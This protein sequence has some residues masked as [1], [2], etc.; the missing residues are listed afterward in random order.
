MSTSFNGFTNTPTATTKR[1]FSDDDGDL[2]H[3]LY[4]WIPPKQKPDDLTEEEFNSYLQTDEGIQ[5]LENFR[6]SRGAPIGSYE[7][8]TKEPYEK[9]KKSERKKYQLYFEACVTGKN[10]SGRKLFPGVLPEE[11]YPIDIWLS[12]IHISEP[13]RPY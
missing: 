9:W 6:T 11:I 7:K 8:N 10:V 12:L 5:Y 2:F 13:T 1:G 4:K 3:K